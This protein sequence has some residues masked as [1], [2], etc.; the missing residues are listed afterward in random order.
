M[1]KKKSE[2]ILLKNCIYDVF[3]IPSESKIWSVRHIY[4]DYEMPL[5]FRIDSN[6]M[7][8]GINE[9]KNRFYVGKVGEKE[10]RGDGQIIA[11]VILYF[12]DHHTGKD[13]LGNDSIHQEGI[14]TYLG[15][16]YF[17]DKQACLWGAHGSNWATSYIPNSDG[18]LYDEI[19]SINDNYWKNSL[20]AYIYSLLLI[21]CV[22]EP[23]MLPIVD[24]IKDLTNESNRKYTEAQFLKIYEEYKEKYDL[25][26]STQSFTRRRVQT[27]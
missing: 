10:E 4:G 12:T 6:N 8:V 26:P 17:Y 20:N 21:S 13:Y 25:G 11:P 15:E 1:E 24:T 14:Q 7:I 22:D 9:D 19:I 3:K 27:K 5:Y 16:I 23:P 2:D 18:R